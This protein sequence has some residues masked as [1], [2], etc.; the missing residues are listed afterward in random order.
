MQCDSRVRGRDRGRGREK[1][2][3]VRLKNA[4]RKRNSN[5]FCVRVH[6]PVRVCR[7]RCPCVCVCVGFC[8]SSFSVFSFLDIFHLF[9]IYFICDVASPIG[10]SCLRPSSLRCCAFHLLEWRCFLPNF[11]EVMP[12]LLHLL[13]GAVFSHHPS[14]GAASLLSTL[15][16]VLPSSLPPFGG[17]SRLLGSLFLFLSFLGAAA[18]LP[19]PSGCCCF[20]PLPFL[21]GEGLP[22]TTIGVGLR[23]PSRLVGGAVFPTFPLVVPPSPPPWWCCLLLSLLG[24]AA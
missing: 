10:W 15:W 3:C 9:I 11:R 8:F 21:G 16:V 5:N 1:R 20:L 19:P 4:Y 13:G 23:S 18:Y 7:R 2:V 6:V 12:S 24:A 22:L 17:A 14:G